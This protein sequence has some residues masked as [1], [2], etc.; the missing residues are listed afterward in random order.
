VSLIATVAQSALGSPR[1]VRAL[2]VH[3]ALSQAF[4]ITLTF[5]HD[6]PDLDTEALLWAEAAVELFDA[7]GGPPRAAEQYHG[8]IEE[9]AWVDQHGDLHLYRLRLR[10]RLH[11]LAYR[12]R[13]RIFQQQSVRDIVARVL[14]EAGLPTD[15][16]V[17]HVAPPPPREYVTQWKESEFAFVS[18]LLEEE[19]MFYWHAH[20]PD[21]H[22][23][24]IA[25]SPAVHEAIEGDPAIACASVDA[26]D[27]A[28][29]HVRDLVRH[30]RSSAEAFRSRDWNPMFA[31]GA[32]EGTQALTPGSTRE[33]HEFPGGFLTQPAG[34]RRARDRMVAAAV[35]RKELEGLSNSPRL[36]P[37]RRFELV[38]VLPEHLG[39][40]HLVRAVH[41]TYQR[42]G[43]G[44][45]VAAV[46]V[47][48]FF[49]MPAPFEFRPARV[50]PRPRVHGKESAVV[51]TPGGE[52]IH[53]DALGRIK[54]HFYWDREGALDDTASCWVR[55]QQQNTATS[56]VI[57]R[58]G[59]EVDVGFE[60]GDPD[61][62]VVLQKL[63]NRETLPPY[64]LPAS[65]AR[66]ALQSST[67]PGGGGTNEIRHDDTAGAMEFFVHA[68]RNLKV[69]VG[70]DHTDTVGVD[71]SA[72]VGA[73]STE[74]VAGTESITVGGHQSASVT[75][76][77]T[78]ETV[79][80]RTVSV[81]ANDETGV[82]AMYG[83]KTAGART[84]SIGGLMNV[85]AQQV[86]ETFNAS[87]TATIGGAQ[88]INSAKGVAFS[89]AGGH[90]ELV[91]AAKVEAARGAKQENIG[92]AKSLT[93]GIVR[94]KTGGD[95]TV[96]SEGAMAWNIGGPL[97][98]KAGG[99]VTLSGSSVTLN[100]AGSAKL[101]AGAKVQATPASVKIQGG[102]VGGD[103][104]EIKVSG[105]VHY[106]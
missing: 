19:G 48:R 57:P 2:E 36:Q 11:G 1:E 89:I 45:G 70:H 79:G 61:R 15:A 30:A 78:L 23:L 43:T 74:S 18:R 63:Y 24:H 85:L 99:A 10:P 17:W 90:T 9:A 26:H 38:D 16:V 46:Y 39:G 75:G 13:T 86:S 65:L 60:F 20:G 51:T 88:S 84:E 21:G 37:G 29:E 41:R 52:E 34:A 100:I 72:Q 7:D 25:D 68:Q 95:M 50:T 42:G 40:E 22:T 76:S 54:V 47:A 56:L 102:T 77:V 4:D 35:P 67:S 103:G 59:W 53:C 55:V 82:T 92:A 31:A 83:V 12:V 66:S 81:G 62:P 33:H 96:A 80:A 64:E 8:V 14:R 6:D 71:A 94:W 97:Q 32:Q 28:A 105:T 93:A 27:G 44:D 49:A 104:A 73:A 3:D 106:K 58:V 69:M 87:H 5:L 101:L 98:I 91:G